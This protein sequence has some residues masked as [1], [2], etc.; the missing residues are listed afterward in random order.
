MEVKFAELT[1]GCPMI[2]QISFYVSRFWAF[3][4]EYFIKIS[5][6]TLQK[7]EIFKHNI[8]FDNNLYLI[9]TLQQQEILK[10]K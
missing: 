4:N 6:L 1:T 9:W 2:L 7:R 5:M 10:Y 3:S 8:M